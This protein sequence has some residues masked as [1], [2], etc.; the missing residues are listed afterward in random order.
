LP[1]LKLFRNNYFYFFIGPG[2]TIHGAPI[3]ACRCW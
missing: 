3:P 2:T 1:F